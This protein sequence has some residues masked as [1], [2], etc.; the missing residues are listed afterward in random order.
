MLRKLFG[1]LIFAGLLAAL[2]V[3][4]AQSGGPSGQKKFYTPSGTPSTAPGGSSYT[5]YLTITN[6]MSSNQTLGSANITV[7]SGFT[8]PTSTTAY[9]FASG[10]GKSW[11]IR[12]GSTLSSTGPI[13]I[14]AL[15]NL[16]VLHPG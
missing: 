6:D 14:G 9:N 2:V 7:P 5:Q 12:P 15:T 11:G 1:T 3:G 10:S 8:V 16:D 13:P 4:S